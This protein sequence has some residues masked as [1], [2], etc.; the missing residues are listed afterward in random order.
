[1]KYKE[2]S[3]RIVCDL[4]TVCEECNRKLDNEAE[5]ALREE[6]GRLRGEI[7]RLRKLLTDLDHYA[8]HEPAC[9]WELGESAAECSCG[10]DRLRDQF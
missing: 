10:L 8:E 6:V 9:V 2:L 7:V 3:E 1:M 4:L 5:V